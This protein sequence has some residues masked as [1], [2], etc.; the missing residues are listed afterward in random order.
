MKKIG[1]L[2]LSI[3][4]IWFLSSCSTVEV[5]QNYETQINFQQFKT[6][7]WKT[8][9]IS[10]I[11]DVKMRQI[12]QA[13]RLSIEE[14]MQLL[15]YQLTTNKTADLVLDYQLDLTEKSQEI[16]V[17]ESKTAYVDDAR[18][19]S[20]DGNVAYGPKWTWSRGERPKYQGWEG[21]QTQYIYY[22]SGSINVL[23]YESHSKQLVWHGSAIKLIDFRASSKRMKARTAD[24]IKKLFSN[25]PV[26]KIQ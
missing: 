11:A 19:V 17:N 16:D 12:D 10:Q 15:G 1:W 20:G 24:G 21:P 7:R 13:L 25:F 26:S 4:S 3:I 2:V 14:E 6:Y 9:A 22:E 8:S 23:M 5:S 18:V